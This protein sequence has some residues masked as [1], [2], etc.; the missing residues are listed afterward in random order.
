MGTTSYAGKR[1]PG[2]PEHALMTTASLRAGRTLLSAT[3]D[4]AGTVDV[5]DANTAQA[6]GRAIFGL[7]V[8]RRRARGRSAV[9]AAGRLAE[10][11]RCAI[12]RERERQRHR[13]QVLRAGAGSHAVLR[14]ALAVTRDRRRRAACPNGG[15]AESIPVDGS[16]RLAPTAVCGALAPFVLVVVAVRWLSCAAFRSRGRRDRRR[17]RGRHRRTDTIDDNAQVR[18]ERAH[19]TC[20]ADQAPAAR[21][22]GGYP[23]STSR[24]AERAP[25]NRSTSG[26]SRWRCARSWRAT[27]TTPRSRSARCTLVRR[28][29]R[30]GRAR[31]SGS[32]WRSRGARTGPRSRRS[33]PIRIRSSRRTAGAAGGVERWARALSIV[34]PP[35]VSVPAEPVTLPLRRSAFGTPVVTVRINGRP[36]DSGSTPARA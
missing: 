19:W 2:V 16:P 36:H 29:P 21:L 14:F 34:P 3:A 7:A 26:R 4:L 5:D 30:C 8:G 11:R 32:R 28:T 33:A 35:Q 6:P 9:V 22:L 24:A 17:A 27:P 31:A 1:I 23:C 18:I 10:P 12:R 13:G 15:H 20:A 25:R